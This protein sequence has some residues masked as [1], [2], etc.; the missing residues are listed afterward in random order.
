MFDC[1][2]MDGFKSE[3]IKENDMNSFLFWITEFLPARVINDGETPYLE[4]YYLFSLLGWT[5]YLHRFVGSDP[6]RGLHDHPWRR[7]FSI[8]LSG[9]YWEN[10]RMGMRKIRWF[11]TLTGDTFHRVVLPLKKER[12]YSTEQGHRRYYKYVM[13]NESQPCWS[14]FFHTSKNV[15]KWGFMKPVL[16]ET[17]PGAIY[18]EYQYTR[19]GDQKEWYMRSDTPTGRQLRMNE[20]NHE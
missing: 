14:L 19:E 3:K 2:S 16:F 17:G 12:L 9:W 18:L 8:I 6:D 1:K 4:R 13:V 11:N 15:K 7:A 5:F 10:T 20:R